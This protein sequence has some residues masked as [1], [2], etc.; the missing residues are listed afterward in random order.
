MSTTEVIEKKSFWASKTFW[1]NILSA[2]GITVQTK[3]GFLIDPATQALGL[4][5]VNTVLRSVTKSPINW[6]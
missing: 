3:T 6:S 5:V 2:L 1:V 4:T